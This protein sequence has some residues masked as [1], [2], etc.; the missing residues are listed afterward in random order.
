MEHEPKISLTEIVIITPYLLLIDIIGIAL[1]TVGM[2]DFGLLDIVRFPI[3]QL[4]IRIKGVKGNLDLIGNIVKLIPY[5]GVIPFTIFWIGT[6]YLD[7]NPTAAGI[8]KIATTKK[9]VSA[10]TPSEPSPANPVRE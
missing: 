8:A 1:F 7:R 2:D 5:V 6:I 9:A 10:A 4:Y 3:T